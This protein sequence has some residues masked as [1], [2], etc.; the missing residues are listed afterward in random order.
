MKT[1][2]I[3]IANRKGGVGKTTTAVNL[4][5]GLDLMQKKVTELKSNIVLID[6]DS[7]GHIAG[8]LNLRAKPCL[9]DFLIGQKSYHQVTQP[10]DGY[11]NLRVI[12]GNEKTV[13]LEGVLLRE[14]LKLDHRDLLGT[15][16]VSIVRDAIER[17]T[18]DPERKTIVIIDTAPGAALLQTAA[19]YAADWLLIP[20]VPEYASWDGLLRLTRRLPQM[21]EAGS[22]VN[23]L[24]IL[25]VMFSSRRSEHNSIMEEW[26]KRF[27]ATP[28]R[29][30]QMGQVIIGEDG[31]PKGLPMVML[32]IRSLV[33][34]AEAPGRRKSIW[35]YAPKS[36]GAV[37]YRK[38]LE[39]VVDR[40]KLK[41]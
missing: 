17:I 1:I 7:Q 22:R 13:D 23:L 34:I 12:T 24:G 18:E 31:E 2:T 19:V 36:Q 41:E 33:E 10:V 8:F 30:K 20:A 5:T 39:Y 15:T 26:Q 27:D 3:A 4:A 16:V 38:M 28:E 37:D 29:L 32:P 35:R 6:C 25:P 21:T 11:P 9:H 40:T 14:L